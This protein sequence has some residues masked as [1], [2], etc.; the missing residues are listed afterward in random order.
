MWCILTLPL[1]IVSSFLVRQLA[2]PISS[3][4]FPLPSLQFT[5]KYLMET[6]KL[7]RERI[8]SLNCFQ[9]NKSEINWKMESQSKLRGGEGGNYRI[10]CRVHIVFVVCSTR[11]SRVEY[12]TKHHWKAVKSYVFSRNVRWISVFPPSLWLLPCALWHFNFLWHDISSFLF[13]HISSRVNKKSLFLFPSQKSGGYL[14]LCRTGIN[15][16]RTSYIVTTD[17]TAGEQKKFV[18]LQSNEF[19]NLNCFQASWMYI[20]WCRSHNRVK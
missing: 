6:V 7:V 18:S 8:A 17:K 14:P 3:R 19:H 11:N 9:R 13:L 16:P 1:L 12:C 10:D 20:Y 2:F 15:E 4:I 5:W